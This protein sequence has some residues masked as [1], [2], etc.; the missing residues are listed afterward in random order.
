MIR[1]VS[2]RG[3]GAEASA[4]LIDAIDGLLCTQP[5]V[6]L[7]ID[8]RCGAGKTTLA[9]ALS[10]KYAPDVRVLHTD[11]Y[12]LPASMRTKERLSQ[13]GGNL[14]YERFYDEAVQHI[15]REIETSRYDCASGVML[16]PRILPFVRLTIV[17]GAYSLHPYFGRYYDMAVFMD[18]DAAEQRRRILAR[19]PARAQRFFDEWIPLEEA[20]FPTI[21][22]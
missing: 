17:E 19:A 2:Q 12:F 21:E 18:I 6:V 22:A 11:D 5:A 7:A 15:S 8:G 20:Y 14:H 16:P 10:Q 1:L 3:E 13:P 4:G 9:A